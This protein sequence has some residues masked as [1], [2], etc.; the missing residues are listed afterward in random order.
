MNKLKTTDLGGFRLR[1]N[2]FR[3]QQN[4]NEMAFKSILNSVDNSKTIILSGC[5]ITG[6]TPALSISSGYVS[7]EGEVIFVPAQSFTVPTLP[8]VAY[9][10]VQTSWDP[11][12]L[13]VF[14]NSIAH[15]TY[16][17]RTAVVTTGVLPVNRTNILELKTIIQSIGE[18]LSGSSW[19]TLPGASYDA[20]S[21]AGPAMIMKD[22]MG[23]VHF[24]GDW[25]N[26]DPSGVTPL[27]TLPVGYRPPTPLHY[28]LL[29][30]DDNTQPL[31]FIINT[32]GT[33]QVL[34]GWCFRIPMNQ[35]TPFRV[36]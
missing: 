33:L 27:A 31:V 34:S 18:L 2:D 1:S 14:K 22:N 13:K 7:I 23:F 35:I 8:D 26:E 20:V 21:P 11:T 12:G 9:L 29:N 16:E 32:D 6:I 10:E 4:A 15:D 30:P 17:I 19:I 5:V 3:W 28:H 36:F 24:K 25:L